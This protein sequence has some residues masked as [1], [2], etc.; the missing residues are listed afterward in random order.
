MAALDE[1]MSL[2]GA[3]AAID[4]SCSGELHAFK[5]DLGPETAELLAEV[6]AA[7]IAMYRME[8]SGWEK[9]TGQRGFFP[10]K[11]FSLIGL[12]HVLLASDSQAV[13]VHGRQVDYDRCFQVLNSANQAA[14][15]GRK[16]P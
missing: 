5:G 3:F 4:F 1:L 2:P 14:S 6:C 11:G 10:G 8:A 13:L 7:N 12:D 9:H 15:P 16:L